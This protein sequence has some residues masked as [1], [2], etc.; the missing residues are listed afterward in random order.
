MP[1][2]WIYYEQNGEQRMVSLCYCHGADEDSVRACFKRIYNPRAKII[3]VEMEEE[4]GT[5]CNP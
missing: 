1:H 3:K 2:A 5:T 4:D